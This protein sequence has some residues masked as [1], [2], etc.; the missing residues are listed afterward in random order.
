[1]RKMST[2]LAAAAAVVGMASP[3]FAQSGMVVMTPGGATN[4]AAPMQQPT[5]MLN[6]NQAFVLPN[7]FAYISASGGGFNYSRGMGGNGQFDL[8]LNAILTLPGTF[9]ATLAPA[10]KLNLIKNGNMSVAGRIGASLGLGGA[11]T[12]GLTAGLP[13]TFDAGAGFLTVEPG[14]SLPTVVGGATATAG[15]AAGAGV[16]YSLPVGRNLQLMAEVRPL[17]GLDG[18]GFRLPAAAGLRFSPM[19]N[20]HVDFN[21]ANLTLTPAFA[22]SIGTAQVIGHVGF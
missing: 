3:A 19:A 22:G 21:L 16:L 14:V 13:L 9:G 18:S 11:T 4:T 2:L 20:A 8:G 10:Y 1:M 17:F 7:G 6:T 12:V 5:A 15:A